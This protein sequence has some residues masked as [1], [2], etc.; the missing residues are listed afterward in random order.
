MQVIQPALVEDG[1]FGGVTL[2]SPVGRT[3]GASPGPP[4]IQPLKLDAALE[5]ANRR[6]LSAESAVAAAASNEEFEEATSA[7]DLAVSHLERI[8][9][10]A[11]R[12]ALVAYS[13]NAP[14]LDMSPAQP[15]RDNKRLR[16]DHD[17][18]V[19]AQM[20][21]AVVGPPEEHQVTPPAEPQQKADEGYVE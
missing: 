4:R 17:A 11:K 6:V 14:H 13:L 20:Q 15:M 19:H 12:C 3:G 8:G 5:A 16:L 10:C 7:L 1:M 9:A 18:S 21:A 2:S